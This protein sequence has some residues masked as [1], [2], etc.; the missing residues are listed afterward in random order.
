MP[1]R[2]FALTQRD[3]RV[4]AGIQKMR[5][6][7]L[8]VVAGEGCWLTEPRG[9]RLLDL[10][11]SVS[12]VGHGHPA[13]V[14]AVTRAASRAS[15]ASMLSAAHPD[16]VGL[17]EDLLAI[18]PGSADR[19]VYLGH[20]GSD[21]C[22]VALRACRRAT[23]RSRIV[24][25]QHSYHGGFGVAS[26]VSW[27][28]VEAGAEPDDDVAF[29]P[30]PDLY[31]PH[32]GDP[33]TV[34]RS[35]LRAVEQHVREGDVACVIVEA[36]QSDGGIIV[37][38]DGF[39]ADL[40]ALCR[41]YGVVLICDEVKVGLGRTGLMHA[42]ECD[43]VSPDVITFGK[44]LGG[45]LPLSAAVGP[46]A[47][48]EGPSASALL[49]T[50]GNPICAA[51]GRAVLHTLVEGQ[52]PREAG[53]RGAQM[54]ELLRAY[55]ESDRPGAAFIGQLRGR[56]LALGIDLVSDQTDRT[57]APQL[58]SQVVYRAWQLGAIVHCVGQNVL[59]LA[60]PLVI[61]SDEIVLACE[62]VANAIDD[63]AVG[64]VTDEMV[65]P[66]AH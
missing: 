8:E 10:C 41:R 58:A 11:A 17:A 42:F 62:M 49:S 65:T 18:T 66:P 20:A 61:S 19:R 36:I 14:E 3:A 16:S 60:P 48:L 51:A 33:G 56:G 38:P 35:S 5:P 46:A 32:N 45:S 37:P 52:L 39:L 55:A 50:A 34:S 64:K 63:A 57:P 24:A 40:G 31:R 1:A 53:C 54:V 7:P 43:G 47:L 25:F 26:G 28:R 59:E 23:G 15:G 12:G 44:A 22:D 21:A 29:V 27:M 9:R 30:Y 6:F 2:E 13:V 4:L